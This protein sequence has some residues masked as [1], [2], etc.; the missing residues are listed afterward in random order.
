L[1]IEEVKEAV[2]ACSSVKSP[3][4]GG[5]NFKFIKR[6]WDLIK[7]EF[8]FS[9][10]KYLE[11]YGSLARG[12]NSSFIVLIPKHSDP[13]G[14]SDYHPISLIG[15]M[16]NVLAKLLATHLNKIIHKLIRS[17]QAAFLT[18]RQI[19]D[20]SLI[21]KEIIN[22][23]RAEKIKLLLFKVDFEKAFDGVN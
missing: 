16:Y 8:F 17:N 11:K 13:L 1:T 3:C 15:C 7:F 22:V 5:L 21:A 4:P 9:F 14:T 10:I 6:Y 23:A 19:L 20:G 12:C 2:W 18:G